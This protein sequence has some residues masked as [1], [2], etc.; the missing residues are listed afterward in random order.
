[1][2]I[3]FM[4]NF[5]MKQKKLNLSNSCLWKIKSR[6][7]DNYKGLFLLELVN[8]IIS[9]ISEVYTNI[10][11]IKYDIKIKNKLTTGEQRNIF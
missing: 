7:H 4:K 1:M 11:D 5:M 2:F 6:L 10:L 8:K 3:Q 9:E